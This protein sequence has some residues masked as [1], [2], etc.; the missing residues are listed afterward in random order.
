M[1]TPVTKR[2]ARI[3]GLLLS[4][5][6]VSTATP[7]CKAAVTPSTVELRISFMLSEEIWSFSLKAQVKILNKCGNRAAN[8]G[9]RTTQRCR[10]CHICDERR[11]TRLEDVEGRKA[12]SED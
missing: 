5:F 11:C 3:F 6:V 10:V 8:Y 2:V 12:V 4:I 7:C 9:S 1:E